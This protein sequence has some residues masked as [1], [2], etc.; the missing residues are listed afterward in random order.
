[1]LSTPNKISQEW[2]YSGEENIHFDP[3][4]QCLIT[5]ARLQNKPVSEQA[6]ISGLALNNHCLTPDTFV[7]AAERAG[8]SAKVLAYSL[9]EIFALSLPVILLMNNKKACILTSTCEQ[10]TVEII[11][12]ENQQGRKKIARAYLDNEYSGF[13]I[14]MEA[15]YQF[16]QA[17]AQVNDENQG[18]WFW[19]AIKKVKGIYAEVI[20]ASL[21]INLFALALPLFSMNVYDRVV[22]NQAMDTLWVMA[23]GLLIVFSFDFILRLI[24][25]YYIEAAG[26]NIDAKLSS[27]IYAQLLALKMKVRPKS[28]G[29][30]A[31]MVHSFESFRELVTSASVS[32]LVDIPFS[33]LFI[34]MV[35]VMGGSL[36]WVSVVCMPLIILS[37]ICVEWPLHQKMKELYRFSSEKQATL[38]ESLGAAETIKFIVAESVMQSKWEQLVNKSNALSIQVK[39][40]SNLLMNVSLFLQYL[41]SVT[42]IILGVYKIGNA[43]LTVGGLIA[44]TILTS[45]ALAPMSQLSTLI[46]RYFQSNVA[47]KSIDKMMGQETDRQKD[48]IYLHR[49][50]LKGG[51]EFKLANFQYQSS[52]LSVLDKCSFKIT[53]GEKVGI[54]GRI[55]S[56]KSTLGKLILGLETLMSGTIL[57]DGIDINQIDPADLRHNIGYVPQDIVLFDGTVRENM[58]LADPYVND[59]TIMKALQIS[60]ADAFVKRHPEGLDMPVGEKGLAIS[61][62]QRQSLAIARALIKN[63]AI[64]ILDEP[65]SA[66]D[67]RTET[68]FKENL[69]KKYQEKTLILVTQRMSALSL[70]DRLVLID[71]GRIVADGPKNKILTALSEPRVVKACG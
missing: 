64:L 54:I 21:L 16:R 33:V 25:H 13:A 56:G 40:F 15:R 34:V 57:I 37:G 12:A 28:V 50:R 60:G 51:I 26:K 66:M 49:P 58:M 1:M 43:Q 19:D 67:E 70:V 62:G 71:G 6:L 32:L 11:P 65:T 31:N 7:Q 29:V 55:G 10:A 5:M 53:P 41:A 46:S 14:F 3:L 8:F 18:H 59:V 27:V 20:A 63:P 47:L 48:K 52:S 44:S 30:L 61:G 38:I 42:V 39:F 4:L 22:P 68:I 24:R 2:T 17:N 36:A 23:I 9:D 35:A 45:R 69:Q